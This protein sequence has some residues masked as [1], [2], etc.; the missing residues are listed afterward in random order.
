LVDTG[1]S[2]NFSNSSIQQEFGI[3]IIEFGQLTPILMGTE[4]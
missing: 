2:D 3:Q 1:A 4:G